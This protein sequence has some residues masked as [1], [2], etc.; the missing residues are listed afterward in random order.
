LVITEKP[1][2]KIGGLFIFIAMG[3]KPIAMNY[4][5]FA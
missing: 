5:I 4:C 3:L 2:A 1:P